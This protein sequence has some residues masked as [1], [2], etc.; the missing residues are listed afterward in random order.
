MAQYQ[1][2]TKPA[3]ARLV[4]LYQ[5]GL[6]NIE[7]KLATLYKTN[8]PPKRCGLKRRAEDFNCTTTSYHP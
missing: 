5:A 7:A 1:S 4:R 3:N 2:Y 8:I 6:K